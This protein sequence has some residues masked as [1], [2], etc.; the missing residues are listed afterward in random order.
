MDTPRRAEGEGQAETRAL[1]PRPTRASS[2]W[3]R[4]LYNARPRRDERRI[5]VQTSIRTALDEHD[6]GNGCE[7]EMIRIGHAAEGTTKL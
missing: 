5:A 6:E 3:L 7:H 2:R 4:T 1:K